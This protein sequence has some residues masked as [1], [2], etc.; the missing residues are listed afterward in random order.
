MTAEGYLELQNSE[1]AVV[2]AASRIFSAYVVSGQVT[3]E[4]ESELLAKAARIALQLAIWTDKLVES[5]DET[6]R[7]QPKPELDKRSDDSPY[8]R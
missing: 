6:S 7:K 8:E 5:D 3:Q 4:N 2:H 1:T